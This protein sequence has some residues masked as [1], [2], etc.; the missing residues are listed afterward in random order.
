MPRSSPI[1]RQSSKRAGGSVSS[2]L[3]RAASRAA[4]DLR[5]AGVAR[6]MRALVFSPMSIDLYTTMIGSVPAGGNGGV[7]GSVRRGLQSVRLYRSRKARRVRCGAESAPAAHDVRR[8]PPH[9]DQSLHRPPDCGHPTMVRRDPVLAAMSSRVIRN[10]GDHHLH[11]RNDRR[12][13]SNH[14]FSRF[15]DRAAPGPR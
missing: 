13:E 2:E 12:T 1:D 6:G 8:C 14:A 11:Q 7:R 15:S 9:S 5:R 3:D 4:Q 10:A